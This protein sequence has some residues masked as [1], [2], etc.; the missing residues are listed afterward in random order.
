MTRAR[1]FSL[2]TWLVLVLTLAALVPAVRARMLI[3][4]SRVVGQFGD[5]PEDFRYPIGLALVDEDRF[6][7]SDWK[8]GRVGLFDR[9]GKLQRPLYPEGPGLQG[10]LGIVRDDRGH[11]FV[12]ENRASRIREF[13]PNGVEVNRFGRRGKTPGRFIRPRGLALMPDGSLL[14]ADY[15]NR[16]LQH[17]DNQGTYL[18]EFVYH[19]EGED[20]PARPR[21]VNVDQKGRVWATY[22]GRHEVARFAADGTVELVFGG[23]GKHRG[24]FEQPRYIGFDVRGNVY[25]S[26]YENHR[27]QKFD[28]EGQLL[29]SFGARG[30]SPGQFHNPEAVALNTRGDLFVADTVNYR[31]QV[32][33]LNSIDARLNLA[34]AAREAGR[35]DEALGHY[36]WVLKRVP[37]EREA[38]GTIESVYVSRARS[39]RAEGRLDRALDLYRELLGRIPGHLEA[40]RAIRELFWER[41]RPV[42]H[43]A[44]LV[45]GAL[46]SGL[47]M[48]VF[49]VRAAREEFARRPGD[50]APEPDVADAGAGAGSG[51]RPA[52]E[53]DAEDPPRDFSGVETVPTPENAAGLGDWLEEEANR[54]RPEPEEPSA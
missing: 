35:I 27:V 19:P 45:L 42:L 51:W 37:G 25:V 39:A 32:L 17:V 54:P 29:Y 36:E 4:R 24:L 31:V 52:V 10:P 13:D 1:T 2:R 20:L 23:K 9:E 7:V 49:L 28:P 43:G 18:G 11:V 14:V 44:A 16:R 50:R 47:L 6:W 5:G 15:G 22:S 21:G 34:F 41:S 30:G 26:D 3:A 48:L 38:L 53:D 40:H 8:S 46:I 33:E 12:V